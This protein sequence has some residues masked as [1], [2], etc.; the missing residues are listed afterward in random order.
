MSTTT[1]MT[2]TTPPPATEQKGFMDHF[3]SSMKSASGFISGLINTKDKKDP[4]TL[5]GGRSRRRRRSRSRSRKGGNPKKGMASKSRKGKKDFVTHKGDKYYNKK[6]HRQSR[7]AKGKR[8]SPY[9]K[10]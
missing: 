4:T 5:T 10:H 6:G 8:K 1:A 2:T 9:K 7:N 3:N